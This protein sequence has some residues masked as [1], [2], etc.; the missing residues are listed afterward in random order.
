MSRLKNRET[1]KME[2]RLLSERLGE[3]RETGIV[4]ETLVSFGRV[5]EELGDTLL[6][7]GGR[8]RGRGWMT[9]NI[10]QLLEDRR[11]SKNDKTKY[12][13]INRQIRKEIRMA[14]E[15]WLKAQCEEIELL[16]QKYETFNMHKRVK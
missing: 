16:E 14:K 9:D 5:F 4:E 13:D 2:G 12:N 8:E 15:V 10:L 6:K 11:K 3:L 7:G 1:R